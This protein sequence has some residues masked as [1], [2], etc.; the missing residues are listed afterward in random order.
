MPVPLGLDVANPK[1][2]GVGRF[3][4]STSC[5]LIGRGPSR[6]GNGW[7][8]NSQYPPPELDSLSAHFAP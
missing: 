2:F 8:P 6:T 7:K 3:R 1:A 4:S 5:E